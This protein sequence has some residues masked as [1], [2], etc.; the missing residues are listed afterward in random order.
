MVKLVQRLSPR[1]EFVAVLA[2]AFGWFTFASVARLLGSG[3]R[4]LSDAELR[5][6]I[7]YELAIATVLLGFLAIRG[8]T[9]A[10][11]GLR[12]TLGDTL[13][14]V[15]LFAVGFCCVLM[16]LAVVALAWPR[17]FHL[18]QAT[19]VPVAELNILTVVVLSVVNGV[20]EELFVCGYVMTAI[21]RRRGTAD[22]ICWAAINVSVVVRFL[23]HTYQGPYAVVGIIPMGLLFAYAYARNARLWPL[24][25]AHAVWDFVAL[26][27]H[28]RV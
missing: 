17:A 8:W 22:P 21:G 27:T 24:I 6:L 14:G 20:Y 10:T 13:W 11:I 1:V 12:P 28:V 2:V 16:A 26:V 18:I 19:D 4:G 7:V 3:T 23:Y 9:A 5:L 15:V 25:V